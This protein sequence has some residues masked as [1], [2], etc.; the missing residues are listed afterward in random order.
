MSD[1]FT[2]AVKGCLGGTF[3]VFFAALSEPLKPKS[4]A[5]LFAAAP[6]IA[7]AALVV[8][9]VANGPHAAHEQSLAMIFGAIAMVCYCVAAVV[10]VNRLGA[11]K[12]SIVAYAAWGAVAAGGY[13]VVLAH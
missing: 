9:G 7:L 12:G 8:T 5:G 13:A 6:S 11:L 10:S 3:V 2:L 4:F 1:V